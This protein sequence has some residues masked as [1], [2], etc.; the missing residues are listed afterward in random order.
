M[1]SE[2]HVSRIVAAI[3]IYDNFERSSETFL[4]KLSPLNALRSLRK[5]PFPQ[6]RRAKEKRMLSQATRY[7]TMAID[8]ENYVV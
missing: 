8:E 2:S 1:E 4:E 7:A 6:R 3:K 5:H